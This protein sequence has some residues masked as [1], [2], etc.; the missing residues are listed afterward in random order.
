MD[1]RI[2]I[3]GTAPSL[4]IAIEIIEITIIT[5]NNASNSDGFVFAS[6]EYI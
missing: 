5:M 3:C 2:G 4:P 6:I 1:K